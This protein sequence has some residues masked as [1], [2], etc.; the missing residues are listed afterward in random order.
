MEKNKI[1]PAKIAEMIKGLIHSLPKIVRDIVTQFQEAQLFTVASSLAYTTLLSI[2]PLLALSFAI[3]QAFGGLSKLYET[4]EPLILS[5]LAEG[6]GDEVL[7]KLHEYIDNTHAGVVGA[8]GLIGLIVTC[9]SM[10]ASAEK[11]INHVW[12]VKITR[13]LFH[14]IASYWLFITLGPL[15]LSIGVGIATS[16]KIPLVNLLPS[17][18]GLYV[19]VV[20]GFTLVYKWVP[21]TLV[22]WSFAIIAANVT[23]VLWTLAKAGY[24]LYTRQVV[25]YHKVY[26][27]LGAIPLLMLWIYI[28]WIIVLTGAA[29]CATLQ[30]R[31]PKTLS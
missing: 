5:N 26:G 6:A 19:I 11:A 20:L 30:K 29:L 8:G 3:F 10:L 24:N 1:T 7:N 28:E 13:S 18:T 22:R 16:S 4:I 9:I 21:Q 27:S 17:G 2:I 25:S 15:A 12:R 23:A 31:I 14:R